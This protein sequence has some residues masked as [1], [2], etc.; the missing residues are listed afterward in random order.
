MVLV[1][2]TLHGPVVVDLAHHGG[3]DDQVYI[4]KCRRRRTTFCGTRGSCGVPE[5]LW[6]SVKSVLLAGHRQKKK[7]RDGGHRV[8][9][10]M[11]LFFRGVVVVGQI[12]VVGVA[13]F[14]HNWH[15]GDSIACGPCRRT[16]QKRWRQ[17]AAGNRDTLTTN[18]A[19]WRGDRGTTIT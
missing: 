11:V 10:L 19:W 14:L 6:T 3:G 1:S 2:F 5:M 12:S 9:P 16:R 4:K 7:W 17:R 13:G 15:G 18:T 8:R